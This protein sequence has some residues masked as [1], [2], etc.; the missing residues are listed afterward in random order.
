[1]V[2][3][4]SAQFRAN[5]PKHSQTLSA[6]AKKA[7]A[8]LTFGR[9]DAEKGDAH[10]CGINERRYVC[11][12]RLR[13]WPL[14]RHVSDLSGRKEGRGMWCGVVEDRNSCKKRVSNTLTHIHSLSLSPVVYYGGVLQADQQQHHH[15]ISLNYQHRQLSFSTFDTARA[16]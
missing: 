1:M 5:H 8:M 10:I 14:H 3:K 11:V 15:T 16:S 13:S 12:F 2:A 9:R 4:V 6:S 7:A